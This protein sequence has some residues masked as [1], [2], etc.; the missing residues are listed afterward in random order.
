MS[1]EIRNLVQSAEDLQLTLK[2]FLDKYQELEENTNRSSLSV[3]ERS[4]FVLLYQAQDEIWDAYNL[5]KRLDEPVRAEGYLEKGSNGRYEVDG[6]ELSS[7]SYIEYFSEDEDG[8]CY[9]PSRLEHNGGD[10][11]IVTL[12][13]EKSIQG[14]K[15]RVK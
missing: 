6:L 3:D 12:G 13:R 9:V 11:Y 10:Y 14:L 7:G 15:V 8:G 2:R 4:Q 1:S 5:L